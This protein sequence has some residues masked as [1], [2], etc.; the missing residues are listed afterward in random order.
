MTGIMRA[1][2]GRAVAAAVA[3]GLLSWLPRPSLVSTAGADHGGP[4]ATAP[5]GPA[6]VG[7]IAAALTLAAGV[8]VV[9]IVK[10]VARRP[11]P[12]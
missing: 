1:S 10:L 4:L 7:V 5:L 11:P 3:A 9:V 6:L 8:A 2:L 12:E